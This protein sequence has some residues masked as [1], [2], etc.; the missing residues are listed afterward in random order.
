MQDRAYTNQAVI[1]KNKEESIFLIA[2]AVVLLFL[3]A[4]QCNETLS[5]KMK[6]NVCN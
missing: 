4:K 5:L 1:H 2:I 6:C 3:Y